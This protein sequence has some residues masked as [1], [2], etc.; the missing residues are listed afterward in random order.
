MR[1]QMIER[2]RESFPVT[3][4]CRCLKVSRSGFYDWSSRKPGKRQKDN[5]CLV[6]KIKQLHL[7]SD[8]VFGSPRIRE[9]LRY[10]GE[11]C[12]PNRV[13]RL[14]QVNAIA[15]IPSRK[16]WRKRK[17]GSRPGDIKNHLNREFTATEENTKWV[18]DITYTNW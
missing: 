1:Y 12:S 13:A 17:S 10:E 6:H 11:R 15:G 14:M 4:M 18:A 2:C 9:E 5:I 16:Q 8:G 7:E 3:M